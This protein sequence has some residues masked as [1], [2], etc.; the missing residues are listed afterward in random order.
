MMVRRMRVVIVSG[1]VKGRGRGI[2]VVVV[3]MSGCAE[4][5]LA[6]SRRFA[7]SECLIL[8]N[9]GSVYCLAAWLASKSTLR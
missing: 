5:W 7:L 8:L 3:G 6:L 4:C 1:R 9:V 2:V